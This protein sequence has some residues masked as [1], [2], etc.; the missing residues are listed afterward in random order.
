MT[1]IPRSDGQRNIPAASAE[2][3][4]SVVTA[5]IRDGVTPSAVLAVMHRGELVYEGG[6]GWQDPETQTPIQPSCLYD[7]ASVTKLFT[8][9][10]FLAQVSAGM[11]SLDMPLA[12]V[13]PEFAAISP[14]S[15]VDSYDPINRK[16]VPMDPAHVGKLVT[17]TSVTMRQLLTHTSGLPPW[18]QF[19]AVA[20]P[21]PT[22]P[23]QLDPMPR[24]LRWA[25]MLG[26]LCAVD[27]AGLPGDKV[28][29]TDIGLMLLGEAV[30][31]IGGQSLE[32][33]IRARVISAISTLPDPITFNPVDQ[34]IG[35][36]HI[37]PTEFDAHWR[38]RRVHG[39]VHDE[40]ACAAGGV[41]GH[42]GLFASAETVA[43]FGQLW[44]DGAGEFNIAPELAAEA[45]R[46]QAVSEGLRRGLGFVIKPHEGAN[47]GD[48][49]SPDTFG[50]TGFTGTSL[51]ID[52]QRKLVV[53]LL[54]NSVYPGRGLPGTYE[55]RR[56]V[57][58]LLAEAL[59]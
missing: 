56:A 2:Q 32:N 58:T 6:W 47:C 44:L 46:E 9:T 15:V 42:A 21:P 16:V 30:A 48:V 26:A 34:R 11:A 5:A 27:F 20:G 37:V 52:P 41:A 49:M 38:Q 59:S 13:V 7:L 36:D 51:W 54:T 55:L 40:N 39:E 57:H 12:D 8:V 43:R 10:A 31:R 14:R 17:P 23:G 1:E 19:Y 28:R 22:P 4:D 50:H 29:Y 35:L 33:G 18:R 25:R 3:L 24:E 45:I 53:A